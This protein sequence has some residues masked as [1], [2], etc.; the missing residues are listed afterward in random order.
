MILPGNHS[1][2]GRTCF[3]RDLF[4]ATATATATATARQGHPFLVVESEEAVVLEGALPL[5][6]EDALE[7]PVR[8]KETCDDGLSAGQGPFGLQKLLLLCRECGRDRPQAGVLRCNL[9]ASTGSQS[10]PSKNVRLFPFCD[11]ASDL[12]DLRI[13]QHLLSELEAVGHEPIYFAALAK[14]AR[15]EVSAVG[16]L[17]QCANGDEERGDKLTAEESAVLVGSR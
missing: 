1:A 3:Q 8:P 16:V 11:G 12:H 2:G 7:I 9:A 17:G 5:L 4:Y 10:P 13:Y 6:A 15:P 14:A